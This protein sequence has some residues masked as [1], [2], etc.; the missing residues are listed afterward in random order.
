M[1]ATHRVPGEARRWLFALFVIVGALIIFLYIWGILMPSAPAIAIQPSGTV[2]I[3]P[4]DQE[5]AL[6]LSAA[7]ESLR[8]DAGVY[9]LTPG[10]FVRARASRNG[11]TCIVNRDGPGNEKPTCYDAVGTKRIVPVD[12]VVGKLLLQGVPQAKIEAQ[13]LAGYRSGSYHV[14]DRPGVAYML[15]DHNWD[16]DPS[17]GKTIVFPPHV[18][19]YAPYM[20][21]KDIG[22]KGDFAYGLPSIGYRGPLGV[23]IVPCGQ[24]CGKPLD[25][26]M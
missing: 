14:A 3:Y 9:V 20:T 15:S 2:H 19:F 11:F 1:A 16:H 17:T 4:R 5:I 7:P 8:Q 18:M 13:I 22:S 24:Y 23:I 26:S 6:A 21:N 25:L 12:L 10:G